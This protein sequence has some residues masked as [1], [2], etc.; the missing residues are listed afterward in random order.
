MSAAP[1]DGDPFVGFANGQLRFEALLGRGAMGAVYRGRQLGLDRRVAIKIITPH[2]ADDELYLE[3][4]RREAQALGRQIHPHIITCHDVGPC[5]GPEGRTVIAM[6]LEYVDGASLGTLLR[7]GPLRVRAVLEL[8]AQAALGLAAAHRLG[9]VHRDVKPD[10]IMVTRDGVAKLADFGLAKADGLAGVTTSG[11]MMGSPAYMSPEACRGEVVTGRGDLYSLGCSL[12]HA[13]TGKPPYDTTNSFAAIR[14]HTTSPV[15][16]LCARRPDLHALEPALKCL[17]AKLPEERPADGREVAKTLRA[18]AATVSADL[19]AGRLD[20]T[21]HGD[22]PQAMTLVELPAA[23]PRTTPH[24]AQPAAVAAARLTK[25]RT[26]RGRRDLIFLMVVA[27]LATAGLV[28]AMRSHQSAPAPERSVTA[29]TG[30]LDESQALALA[31]T[32][33]TVEGLI[34]ERRLEEAAR[35]LAAQTA[36]TTIDD[37][38]LPAALSGLSQRLARVRAEL[39]A[40]GLPTTTSTATTG[41]AGTARPQVSVVVPSGMRAA[42]VWPATE[43]LA[44]PLV[45]LVPGRDIAG[46]QVPAGYPTLPECLPG[47]GGAVVLSA[48]APGG[49]AVR[50][51]REGRQALTLRLPDGRQGGRLLV[52]LNGHYGKRQLE[53]TALAGTQRL[54]LPAQTLGRGWQLVSADLATSPPA[55]GLEIASYS[56]AHLAVSRAVWSPAAAIAASAARIIPGTLLACGTDAGPLSFGLASML[57]PWRRNH[58]TGVRRIIALPAGS[59]GGERV[60]AALTR[61]VA[62]TPGGVIHHDGADFTAAATAA[63]S[64]KVDQ[65]VIL[66]PTVAACPQLRST[67][68]VCSGLVSAGILPVLVIG[69]EAWQEDRRTGW[70]QFLSALAHRFAGI[71]V[72]DLRQVPMFQA[73]HELPTDLGDAG[74]QAL[75]E[76]GLAAGLQDLQARLAWQLQEHPGGG[77]EGELHIGD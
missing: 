50:T 17:L 18:L 13:L 61:N 35:V 43:P 48:F 73:R 3:R 63:R 15:P 37:R 49:D 77:I 45:Q 4:F 25:S 21:A 22:I 75:V 20:P 67:I 33:A 14:H 54:S 72:I 74:V 19:L 57:E 9:I 62:G 28:I 46:W 24:Q 31:E 53:C 58:A 51:A 40:G 26:A 11:T 65:L 29:T 66:L 47:G 42:P 12:F 55:Q 23:V 70:D 59:G 27:A 39:S 44:A 8:H 10:N 6:V 69:P 5:P 32:L 36:A 2:L 7:Q 56:D 52:L 1:G 60:P 71:P 68:E 34:A 38:Q 30:G 41:T 16:D 76:A 64:A